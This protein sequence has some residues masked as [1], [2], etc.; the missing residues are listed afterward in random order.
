MVSG[1]GNGRRPVAEP[2]PAPCAG[3]GASGVSIAETWTAEAIRALVAEGCLSRPAVVSAIA[4]RVEADLAEAMGECLDGEPV[5]PLAAELV[6]QWLD[7]LCGEGGAQRLTR[8]GRR[9]VRGRAAYAVLRRL[10]ETGSLGPAAVVAAAVEAADRGRVLAGD[11]A[12][13]ATELL[14][15]VEA[16][17]ALSTMTVDDEDTNGWAA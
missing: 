13:L 17:A 10:I 2:R 12:V 11:I 3:S 6:D 5:A 15:G 8:D 1:R 16:L 7:D 9:S 4:P 14:G